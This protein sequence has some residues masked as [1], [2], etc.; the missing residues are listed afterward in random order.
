MS[1]DIAIYTR[2]TA[3][4]PLLPKTDRAILSTLSRDIFQAS[5]CLL[6][7]VHSKVVRKKMASLIREMNCYYSNLIEGHKTKPRDIQ[8]ALIQDFS[9]NEKKR[10]NQLLSLAHIQVEELM[11]ERLRNEESMDVYSQD[12]LCWIHHEFYTHLP[13]SLRFAFTEEG[14]K[15]NIVPGEFRKTM[16]AVGRHTPP[17]FDSLDTFLTRFKRFYG[18]SKI[19]DTDRLIAIAA[20][21]HRLAWI[22]PFLDGNGRVMRLHSQALM[23]KHGLASHGLWTL[24]RGL[25]R[26]RERYYKLLQEADRRRIN[27][28][29][30]R[31][32]LSD[33]GLSAFCSFF[34]ETMLDQINFMT[35]IFDLPR[36][37]KR[38][39]HHFQFQAL[40][41]TQY[42]E[43][44]MRVVKNLIEEGEIQR[45]KIQEIT[46]KGATISAKIIKQGLEEELFV[47]PSAKGVLQI[48]FPE[49]VLESYF[50]RLFL[51]LPSRSE[52]E[53]T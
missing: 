9:G 8:R 43:E 6:G 53:N 2:P 50:P 13:E 47:T 22:H 3:M 39:E 1:A 46:G 34:L 21:H 48:N 29:D 32:N 27:D 38:V 36:L 23:I 18:D 12:F 14:E 11:E 7:M 10:E 52:E 31:G 37:R 4:E 51:D 20:A 40:H 16:V 15:I 26:Y 25:A 42:R 45:T 28:Y 49:Q 5:G 35:E 24:S 33:K 44:K 30:G 17:H 41:I 19:Y